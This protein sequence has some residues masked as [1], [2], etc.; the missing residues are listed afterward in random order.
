MEKYYMTVEC[1]SQPIATI[2]VE[3]E[4]ETEAK[5]KAYEAFLENINEPYFDFYLSKEEPTER[6]EIY[7]D[8][9]GEEVE[10]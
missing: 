6:P 2:K 3:A 9:N 8:E 7:I 5:M 10:D 1:Q 4:N